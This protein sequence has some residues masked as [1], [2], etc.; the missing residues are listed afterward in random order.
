MPAGRDGSAWSE[1]VDDGSSMG[2]LDPHQS[3][4]PLWAHLSAEELLRRLTE[5]DTG[6]LRKWRK[7]PASSPVFEVTDRYITGQ[8]PLRA[9]ELPYLLRFERCRFEYPPDL[10]QATILG[11]F[12]ENCWLPGL[13]AR[14][15]KSSND[16]RLVNSTVRVDDASPVRRD[17]NRFADNDAGSLEAGVNLADAE[18]SGSL[19]LTGSRLENPQGKAI[20]ADR[21]SIHG[22]LLAYRLEATGEVRMPGLRTG[23]NVNFA[24]ARFSNP[25]GY[26][27]NG[28]GLHVGGNLLFRTDVT[29]R[30]FSSNGRL[31]LPSSRIE[32]DLVLRGAQLDSGGKVFFDANDE[33]DPH[34][35]PSA[36]LIAD[37]IRVAGNVELSKSMHSNGTLRMLSASIGGSLRLA[38]ATVTVQRGVESPWHDRA[39]HFD[40]TEVLG[41]VDARSLWL[42]GQ[43]RLADMHVH[44]S[45]VLTD[46]TLSHPMRDM[47]TARRSIIGGNLSLVGSE[48]QG[49]LQL[50]GVQV[51]GNIELRGCRLTSARR[52]RA[53]SCSVDARGAT[54]G[55]D[56][57]CANNR[58]TPF[59]AQSGVHMDGAVIKRRLNFG[60]AELGSA[61]VIIALRAPDVRAQELIMTTGKPPR[62][63]VI[64][65]QSSCVS[66]ADNK[67]FWSATGGIELDDFQYDSLDTPVGLKDDKTFNERLG[68]LEKAMHGRYRPG[69]YDQFAAMLRVSGNEE[70]ATAVLMRKQERRYTALAKGYR[71]LGPGVQLWSFL[72]RYMV[73]YGFRPTRAL[74]WLLACLAGGS[75]WF[76]WKGPLTEVNADDTLVWNPVLYT[77]DLLVPI[78]DFGN[79]NRWLAEGENQWIATALIA[80]GWVLATTVAA[81]LT[82]M[83][84]RNS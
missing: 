22:A 45:F 9:A 65:R 42:S 63:R 48:L 29:G 5:P 19:V 52:S 43:A 39:L 60:G 68:W 47:F 8:L 33:A 66:L 36:S 24:G 71:F 44:G 76:W 82:R 73:G 78:V 11:L 56:F 34:F 3:D 72:Q 12:F 37:R 32:S 26:A 1:L 21:L 7:R 50:Q 25:G 16:L 49:T 28:N 14:N 17:S 70:H 83:L 15:L 40:G 10:R 62:G 81:G 51:A 38:E 61:L 59:Y 75:F 64:L 55:R 31:F 27:F 54:V 80:A 57:T 77:V 79:K 23:G 46:G 67:N 18:I 35:D 41:D 2:R 20:R 58:R 30:V 69:P 53:R 84:R 13:L 6:G 74:L 4:Q